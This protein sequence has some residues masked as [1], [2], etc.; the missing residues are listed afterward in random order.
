[1]NISIRPEVSPFIQASLLLTFLL[2]LGLQWKLKSWPGSV[3]FGISIAAVLC[4]YFLFFFRDP[5]RSSPLDKRLIIS[6]ADG[7]VASVTE[8]YEG[9]YLKTD[10]VRVRARA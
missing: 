3:L 10:C 5:E 6:G 1:M 2:T 7:T 9:T 8:I 4:G